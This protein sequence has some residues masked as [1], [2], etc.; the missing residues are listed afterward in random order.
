MDI[1]ASN[2]NPEATVPSND[3]E[4][5]EAPEIATLL[6]YT[7]TWAYCPETLSGMS[8]HAGGWWQGV[9]LI[10]DYQGTPMDNSSPNEYYWRRLCSTEVRATGYTQI[11]QY[12]SFDS[13]Q[14]YNNQFNQFY[15]DPNGYFVNNQYQC[16][17]SDPGVT[18]LPAE[19]ILS[20]TGA[21]SYIRIGTY[22]NDSWQS[23]EWMKIVSISWYENTDGVGNIY[24]SYDIQLDRGQLGTT[25]L[26]HEPDQ[27]VEFW[28]G[29]PPEGVW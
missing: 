12:T 11:K 24:G 1:T 15:A 19:D 3:C 2:Y 10:Q 9:T 22:S 27:L 4:Y 17:P 6:G 20:N 14:Y 28:D 16:I 18:I 26:E 13:G 8:G 25:P 5:A 23:Y 21:G 7:L 29:L